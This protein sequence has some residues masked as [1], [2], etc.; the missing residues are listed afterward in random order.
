VNTLVDENRD[1]EEYE[2]GDSLWESFKLRLFN[3]INEVEQM[4]EEIRRILGIEFVSDVDEYPDGDTYTKVVKRSVQFTYDGGSRFNEFAPYK[5]KVMVRVTIGTHDVYGRLATED[6][7][8]EGVKVASCD[9]VTELLLDYEDDDFPEGEEPENPFDDFQV[10][11]RSNW[12]YPV[13]EC[14]L[15]VLD[16]EPRGTVAPTITINREAF[17]KAE[18][19][20]YDRSREGQLLQN[21][22]APLTELSFILNQQ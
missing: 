17:I 9:I 15:Q 20:T 19:N 8:V 6:D 2:L 1:Q 16:V 5:T 10:L 21:M 13:F 12:M 18:A 4:P 7:Y 3:A 11:E 22:E 14:Q